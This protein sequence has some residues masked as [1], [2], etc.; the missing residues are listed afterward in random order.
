MCQIF[1]ECLRANCRT[2]SYTLYQQLFILINR[3]RS[4]VNKTKDRILVV[5]TN[6]FVQYLIQ[7]INQIN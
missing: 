2:I 5:I 1:G 7:L 6:V 3:I 4:N